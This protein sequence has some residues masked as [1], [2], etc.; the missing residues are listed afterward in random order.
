MSSENTGRRFAVYGGSF[1]PV[2]CGHIE[3]A[4]RLCALFR[5]DEFV[6]VPAFHAPHKRENKPAPPFHRFAMLV[7][8]TADEERVRVS[9]IELDDPEHPYSIETLGKLKL[10]S[11]D[12]EIFF[13]IGAD[14]WQEITTW[15]RWEEVLTSVNIIVV[16]RPGFEITFGHV[17]EEIAERVIDLRG[18]KPGERGL[19]AEVG[20]QEHLGE[21]ASVAA[22]IAGRRIASSDETRIFVTDAVDMDISATSIRKMVREETGQWKELVPET[23]AAHI[24]KYRLYRWPRS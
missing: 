7:L 17:T 11:P 20:K 19:E 23:V 15:R 6:F 10:E 13:V 1:D 12:D 3:I 4:R 24:E 8:A 5:L 2:H 21:A 22:Q 14:S 9:T 16:T 18:Q